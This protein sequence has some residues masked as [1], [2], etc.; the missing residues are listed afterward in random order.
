MKVIHP[1]FQQKFG[2]VYRGSIEFLV[3]AGYVRDNEF[4]EMRDADTP[5]FV[6]LNFAALCRRRAR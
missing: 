5:G 2:D 3:A 6:S 1:P 4:V